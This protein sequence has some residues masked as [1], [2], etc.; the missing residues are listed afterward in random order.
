MNSFSKLRFSKSIFAKF[1]FSFIIVGLIPLLALSYISLNTFSNYLERYAV[2]NFEQMLL[3][4]SKNVDDMYNRYN[5]ES[6]LMYSYGTNKGQVLG[7]TIAAQTLEGDYRL[8]RTVDDFLQTV[9]YTDRHL[10]SVFFVFPNGAYQTVTKQ[11]R[12]FDFRYQFPDR[13]WGEVLQQNRNLLSYFPTHLDNYYLGSNQQVLTFGRNLVNVV[14]APGVEGEIV[15]SLYMDVSMGAFDEIFQQMMLNSKDVV[16]VLDQNNRILYSSD[17]ASIGQTYVQNDSN[18]YF[19]MQKDNSNVAWK[20]VGELYKDELVV[21]TRKIINTI[22]I[23]VGLCIVSL[24]LVAIWFSRRFSKPIRSI[25]SEMAKVESGNFNTQVT[26]QTA[27]ELGLLSRGFNKMVVRLQSYIDEV[28]VAQIKQKH[29][30][31]NALKNQI[32]PHYLYN[33]LEVIRMSAVANDDNEV[34][35]MI[36]SL[37]HQLKYVLDYGQETV[38]LQEEKTNIEQ[39]FRLMELRYGEHKL[40]MDFRFEGDVLSCSL[41]KLSIQP[42][43]ENAIYHGIMPKSGKG[44]IR[45][46]AEKLA[47][48]LLCLTVDDDGVGMTEETLHQVRQ[49]LESSYSLDSGGSSIGLKNVHDRIVTLYGPDYGL[50]I[51]STKHI[52]TSVRMVIPLG[53]VNASAERHNS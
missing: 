36:L 24:I 23:V 8:T 3:F 30:E 42:I 4:A 53:E 34:G 21:R 17:R 43:V 52:G 5:N 31:L 15:G 18:E 16:Y 27:D 44:T 50:E 49:K 32:R 48:N 12:T 28:Y 46:I 40:S 51:N 11:N 20:I 33:T 35:D 9:L 25:T 39:Y 6:K 22:T 47:D 38:A 1:T 7:E 29:A 10:Q 26:V 13:E 41:P 19:R 45:I 14:N 2:T 37:S